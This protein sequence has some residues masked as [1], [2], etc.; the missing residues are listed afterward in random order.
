MWN[1]HLGYLTSFPEELGTTLRAGVVMKIPKLSGRKGF[2]ELCK[3]MG[4]K[5]RAPVRSEVE[6]EGGVFEIS[7]RY[8]MG[9]TEVELINHVMKGAAQFVKW[10]RDLEKED[11]NKD[12]DKEIKAE[13]KKI[14]KF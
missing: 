1:T 3:I 4:L 6:S 5:A 10:E 11:S 13:L 12:I 8:R 9:K 2:T 7:N 14:N